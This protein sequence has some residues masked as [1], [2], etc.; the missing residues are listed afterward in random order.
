MERGIVKLTLVPFPM[1]DASETLPWRAS[2]IERTVLNPI[3]T[4]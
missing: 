3:P 1:S 4:P 2:V